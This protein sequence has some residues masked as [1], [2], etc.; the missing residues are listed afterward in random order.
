MSTDG[1]KMPCVVKFEPVKNT[2]QIGDFIIDL[3][4]VR[5]ESLKRL[6]PLLPKS[7]YHKLKSRIDAR[8]DRSKRNK[9]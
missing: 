3:T 4:V 2:L 6:R 5:K 9:R 7:E 8:I 1:D